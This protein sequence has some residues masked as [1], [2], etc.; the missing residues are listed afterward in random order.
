VKEGSMNGMRDKVVL[1]TGAAGG[2]GRAIAQAFA[3]A[4]AHLALLDRDKRGLDDLAE[5]Q[6][7]LGG[8]VCTAVADLST[9]RG[10]QVGMMAVLANYHNQIDLL[11]SN[12]GV[13]VAGR[14]EEIT[15]AQVE[16][17][18]TM[19][20]LTH[21]WA[22]QTVLPLME[23]REGANIVL[24]GSDQGSQPDIGLFP[25]AQAK[26]ALHNL[27]KELA[28]EYG[29]NI[30]INCIAPGMSRTPLVKVL[31]AKLAREEFHT[32]MS[33]AERLELQRRGVPLGRL[34]EPKEV[35]DAVM[36]LAQNEFCTGTVLDIS[37][38]NVRCV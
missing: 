8:D 10:V 31:M 6:R 20:F 35:A 26:A 3:G 9:A 14:F 28:R 30:R 13:L 21:V 23:H 12:V 16:F 2:F 24:V 38:G 18:L 22:C 29:P 7:A 27:T 4:G 15:D 34:G 17:C 5:S 11:V 32:D 33:T 19:N 25:Y 36:F 37:G 1:I